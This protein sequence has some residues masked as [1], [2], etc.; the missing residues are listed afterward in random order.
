M[1]SRK[2]RAMGRW[3]LSGLRWKTQRSFGRVIVENPEMD[4]EEKQREDRSK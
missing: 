2:A 1:M 4:W 3:V